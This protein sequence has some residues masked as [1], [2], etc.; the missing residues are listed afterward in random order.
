LPD[1]GH[2]SVPIKYPIDDLLVSPAADDPALLKR[3]PL[4][5][6]CGIPRN[7]VGDLLMVWDFCLSFGRV[8][9]LYPFSLA[10]L[11]NAICHK[12]S[13]ALIVEI[14]SAL[15]RLLIEDDADYFTAPQTNKRK[16]KVFLLPVKLALSRF[17]SIH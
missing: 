1:E 8:L 7:S 14:H 11:E 6:D 16:S 12:E 5:T 13:N 17:L 3:P 9:N 4:V 10:D 15:F 2:A